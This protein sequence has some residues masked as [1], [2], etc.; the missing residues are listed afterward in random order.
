MVRIEDISNRIADKISMILKTD[1]DHREILAYGAFS[2]LQTLWSIFL[3]IVFG[4]VF[5][6]LFEAFIISFSGVILRKYS[7]GAHATSP[8]R[9]AVIGA[10]I[11]VVFGL[12]INR[13]LLNLGIVFSLVIVS[14]SFVVS[15]Y[16]INTL[17]PVDT[18]N[19]PIVKEKTRLRLKR[20]SLKTVYIYV[21]IIL[22]L[23]YLYLQIHNIYLLKAILSI[24]FGMLWQSI[25]LTR[26]GHYLINLL[27]NLL[28]KIYIRG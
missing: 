5:N 9:C 22:F 21:V 2:L 1:E 18:P 19:K 13:Y 28:D 11:P 25:T 12:V 17:A 4:I 14:I 10:I 27:D 3:V 7:G 6:V 20:S 26:F 15:Y 8:N 16:L 24:S 23:N